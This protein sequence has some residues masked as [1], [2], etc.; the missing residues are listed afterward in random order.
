[1]SSPSTA[2]ARSPRPDDTLRLWDLASGDTLRVL[3]GHSGKV[4]HVVALDGER[5]LSASYD[6]TLRLWD[7]ATGDTLRVLAGH[8][9]WVTHVVAL[10]RERA[11]S[12][13]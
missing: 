5:A 7:L 13:S 4:T 3:Q 1:M 6:D 8:S 2:S 9:G 12:A 10:G 11:L